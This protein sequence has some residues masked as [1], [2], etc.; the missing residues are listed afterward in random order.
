MHR[1]LNRRLSAAVLATA[2]T[3][4]VAGG[5]TPASA[6][7]TQADST[8]T[9]C[10][11]GRWPSSVQGRPVSLEPG[12]ATGIYLWHNRSG[13]HLRATHPGSKK[14]VLTGR[15]TSTRPMRKTPVA[16]EGA[17]WVALSADRKTI[18]FRFTN[19]GHLDGFDF[20]TACAQSIS[21]TGAVNGTQLTSAQVFLGDDGNHP[22]SVPFRIERLK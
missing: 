2:A 20:T 10:P 17:D 21:V 3:L 22:T 15:I 5:P 19:H 12:A 18:R 9:S 6:A 11:S 13:W 8:T 16:L 1:R 14:V 7:V 4:A